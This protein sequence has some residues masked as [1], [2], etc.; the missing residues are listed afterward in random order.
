MNTVLKHLDNASE[1]EQRQLSDK[2]VHLVETRTSG[3]VF[4]SLHFL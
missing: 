2:S 3:M 1:E 4:S